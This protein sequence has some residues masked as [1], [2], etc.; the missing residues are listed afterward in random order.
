[1]REIQGIARSVRDL[2]KGQKYKIDY[3]QREYRWEEKHVQELIDD[4]VDRFQEDYQPSHQRKQVRD[5]GH[6]FL[7]SIIISKKEDGYYIVDGQ[8]RLTSL[9]LLLMTPLQKGSREAR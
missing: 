5:Y 8:Q 6:Y 9:T 3:Y 2:L 4:L 1:M 7:G